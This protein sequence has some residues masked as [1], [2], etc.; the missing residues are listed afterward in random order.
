MGS[1]QGFSIGHQVSLPGHFAEAV[2][3][4]SVR[5]IGTGYECRVRLTDGSLEEVVISAGEAASL[6]KTAN[7]PQETRLVKPADLQL[8]V[9]SA[10]SRLAA[11]IVQGKA[12]CY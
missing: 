2:I 5:P 12:C 9:E 6:V 10:R 11:Q 1:E 7:A 4:E 3:L 8:L